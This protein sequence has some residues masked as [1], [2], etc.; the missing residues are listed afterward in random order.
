LSAAKTSFSS[1][2][3]PNHHFKMTWNELT[4]VALLGT[5][6]SNLSAESMEALQARG[7]D[8]QQEAT[9]VLMEAAALY[10][11]LRK[12]GFPLEEYPGE[13]PQPAAYEQENLC[14]H[15]SAH[16]LYLIV[17]G[18][19]GA[20]FPEFIE[21]LLENGKTLPPDS[22]PQL[23]YTPDFG[24]WWE[25]LQPAIGAGGRWL[26]A[27]NPEW[28]QW[29]ARH[30]QLDWHTGSKT[31]R[32]DLLHHIR[33]K[34]PS[35]ALPLL[36]ATWKD[37]DYRDKV[38]F[39]KQLETGLS[40]HD[41]PFLENCL[42]EHRKEVREVAARLLAKMTGSRLA[43][44]MRRRARACFRLEGME[45]KVDLSGEPDQDTARDGIARS[46]LVW[47]GGSK[48]AYLGQV[49]ASLHPHEWEVF[50][51][52]KPAE[53]LHLFAQNDWAGTLLKGIVEAS[54]LHADDRWMEAVVSFW[55]TSE[56]LPSWNTPGMDRLLEIIPATTVNSLA[57]SVFKNQRTL[58]GSGSP[59]F[60]LL[61]KN[62]AQWEDELTL[63]L[64]QRLKTW[65]SDARPTD[66]EFY[67]Y[68]DFLPTMAL[69]CKPSL[70]ET[71]QQGWNT[72]APLWHRWERPWEKFLRTIFFR[73]EMI[74]ALEGSC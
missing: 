52:K 42:D 65:L 57:I 50:F 51:Q 5:D 62:P 41:E 29:T 34:A 46:H 13:L 2:K 26:L 33:Q 28:W 69:R 17:S 8:V 68:K 39:L 55:M 47:E 1:A 21:C 45:L 73:K 74:A 18:E 6:R 35:E 27:Q 43:G 32:Q 15:T 38:D 4:K 66:W 23:L 7:I 48:A 54:A 70:Y 56:S 49:V 3:P 53:V 14:S 19:F 71:L 24:R 9:K 37:E 40:A 16:H 44:R 36:D 61:Q 60:K 10:S 31:E 12:A 64:F 11:Q 67:F 72:E 22:L 30:Q 58:P 25:K 63:S 59:V 20:V